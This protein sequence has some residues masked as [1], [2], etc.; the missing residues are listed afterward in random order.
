MKTDHKF[1]SSFVWRSTRKIEETEEKEKVDVPETSFED[2][3]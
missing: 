1:T 3:C 2:L